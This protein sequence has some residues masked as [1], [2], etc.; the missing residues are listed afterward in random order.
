MKPYHGRESCILGTKKITNISQKQYIFASLSKLPLNPLYFVLCPFN[1][2]FHMTAQRL[3]LC[4]LAESMCT[5]CK[6][7]EKKDIMVLWFFI[8][9]PSLTPLSSSIPHGT[10]LHSKFSPKLP[11]NID[12]SSLFH[13]KKGSMIG[14]RHSSLEC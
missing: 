13:V 1:T 9:V 7:G 2:F 4:Q 6:Y 5:W 10:A 3:D 12:Q 11:N 14:V 8:S